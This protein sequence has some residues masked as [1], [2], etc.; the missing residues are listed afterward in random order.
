MTYSKQLANKNI[1]KKKKSMR[2][3]IFDLIKEF[4]GATKDQVCENLWI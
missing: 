3:Q 2:I 1:Q 4:D